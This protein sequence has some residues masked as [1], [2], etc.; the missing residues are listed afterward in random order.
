MKKRIK[1]VILALLSAFLI[2][3]IIDVLGVFT[4]IKYDIE[5]TNINNHNLEF[6]YYMANK[7]LFDVILL[8]MF[9]LGIAVLLFKK[10][11]H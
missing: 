7:M 4:T 6:I 8:T 11:N 9:S 2:Y 5:E 3:K 1:F 10:R